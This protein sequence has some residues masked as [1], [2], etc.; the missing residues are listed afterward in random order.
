MC[1]ALVNSLRK[2]FLSSFCGCCAGKSAPSPPASPTRFPQRRA[3]LA[4]RCCIHGDGSAR[5]N[6][7]FVDDVVHAFDAVLHSGVDGQVY[8]IGTSFELDMLTL[9]RM[10]VMAMGLAPPGDHKAADKFIEFVEDRNI[11]DRRCARAALRIHARGKHAAHRYAVDRSR[12]SEMGWKASTS[13][14]A[15]LITT[16]QW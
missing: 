16:I 11:N 2:S 3:S 1:L 4:R 15:G 10:I 9:A 6:Y 14:E 8:N 7:V 5:R 13:F 12:L